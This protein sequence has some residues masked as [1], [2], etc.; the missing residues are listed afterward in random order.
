MTPTYRN[1]I[2][3]ALLRGQTLTGPP[4]VYVSLHQEDGSEVSGGGY[5]RQPV[6]FGAPDA[7]GTKSQDELL[8]ADLPACTVHYA[9]L[10]SAASGGAELWRAKVPLE[11]S[12]SDGDEAKIRAG[13]L[14]ALFS[15]PA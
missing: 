6:V 10:Q 13:D 2:L 5:A 1:L 11:K 7:G 14:V 8:F 9:A 3:N 4:V 12:Y 15:E